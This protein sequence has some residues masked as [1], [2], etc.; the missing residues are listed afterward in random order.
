VAAYNRVVVDG[1]PLPGVVEP[2]L[3]E[4][5]LAVRGAAAWLGYSGD[6][7]VA[8]STAYTAYG[9]TNV[10]LVAT[11]PQH[12]RRGYGEALTWWATLVR[13]DLP[14]MLLASDDGRPVYERMGYLPLL[15]FAL[16]RRDKR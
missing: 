2:V 14:A 1:F 8:A 11:M 15:R 6:E 12:R 10:T 3:D 4:R 16:W 5:V 7:P 13:P 9:I